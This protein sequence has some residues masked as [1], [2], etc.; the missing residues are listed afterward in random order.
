MA[1][2]KLTI[3]NVA[4]EVEEGKTVLDAAQS[5]SIYVPALCADPDLKP[6]GG[7]R[8]CIVEIEGRDALPTSCTTAAAEGMVVHTRSERVNEV[9]RR[10]VELI[11]ADHDANCRLCPK[12][13]FCDLQRVTNYVSIE[14]QETKK[15][16]G[17]TDV[18]RSHP[19]I[20]IDRRRCILCAKC[21]RVCEEVQGVGALEMVG[22][23]FSAKITAIGDKTLA[24]STCESCGQCLDR[25]PAA[26]IITKIY[27]LPTEEVKTVC[28]Y[29]GVGCGIY[30]GIYGNQLACVRGDKESPVNN[31]NLCVKG[32]FGVVDVI[33]DLERLTSPLVRKNGQ[34]VEATWDEAMDVIGS[35]LA[36]YKGDQFAA[37]SSAKSTNEDNY[38]VQKLARTVMG[39]NNID[40]CARLCHSPTLAGLITSFGSG[41]M[42]NP[43]GEI[44][45]AKCIFAIGT[46]TTAT[47]PIVGLQVKKAVNRNG[48]KLIVA[49]PRQIDL[50]RFASLWLRHRPGTDVALLCGMAWVIL[51]EQL[52]DRSF[53]EERCEDF[54]AFE[55]SLQSLDIE[56]VVQITGVA[57]DDIAAAARMYAENSPASILYAMGI[58]QHSHGTD[59]VLAIANLAM[60]TGNIG[61]PSSGVNPLRGQN[62]VQGACDMGCLP[63]FY[64]GYQPVPDPAARQKFEAAWGCS[65]PSEAG[66]TISEIFDAAR[67]GKIKA[68]YVIGENPAIS[69]PDS[70][71]VREALEK[72]EFLVVQDLFLTE[73]GQFADIVLPA[74]TFAE[75]DGTF[76][77][78]ERRVQRVRRAIEPVGQ[79]RADW[80]IT[81]Q[82]A[83]NLGGNGFDYNHPSQIM[84]EI[85]K[86]VPSYGG[87]S[88]ERLETGGL[89]WPCPT[90]EHPGTPVLHAER[91]ARGKGKFVPVQY[92]PPLEQPDEEYPLV[93]T[94]GRSLYQFHTGTMTRRVGGLNELK[95]EEL[96]E[97]NPKDATALGI[98]DGGVI[99]II[100][101][102]GQVVARAKV[103]EVSP[104]G[105]IFMS[106]H[107]AET[108]TN[109]LTNPA[110]DPVAKIPELKVCTVRIEEAD[111][112]ELP[113]PAYEEAL[114]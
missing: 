59:N 107:F 80:Q 75:R 21:V 56:Q 53:I 113:E 19:F 12:N 9:R 111:E 16:A 51:D 64:P 68:L 47:H 97:I 70:T 63:D 35:K 69:E 109:L 85:S 31:G 98:A 20:V 66:L 84:E 11:R 81:C 13:E 42:T 4:V 6:Y 34:L 96:V 71:R 103:T 8:L 15:L 112:S 94:T 48:A 114:F 78:T 79:S 17:I 91:F 87:I 65:L 62:N 58:T 77:T 100:S 108:A 5:A 86:L 67:E 41:A 2:I 45:E 32:R 102:R 39:T 27:R 30:L 24:E 99:R 54:N 105:V 95:G 38:V 18:D 106:F 10:I 76:T 33:N 61:K 82:I 1:T 104:E 22:Q 46:D 23:G 50:C 3:D 55:K 60:L 52:Y 37:I 26:G 36:S 43:I 89:Q 74:S 110:L 73:T 72:L 92:R 40:H 93:L 44:S 88:Y 25:C 28:P 7:C 14:P 29:C 101:R 83:K 57:R 49:N 90:P